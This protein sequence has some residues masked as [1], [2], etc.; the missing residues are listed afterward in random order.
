[1][2]VAVIAQGLVH[3]LGVRVDQVVVVVLILA[4][5]VRE[6]FRKDFLVALALPMDQHTADQEAVAVLA[7]RV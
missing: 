2:A 6:L 3:L 4:Q 7:L 1:V 5:V